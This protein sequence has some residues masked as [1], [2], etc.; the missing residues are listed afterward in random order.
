MF[1]DPTVSVLLS[2]TT[3]C[4]CLPR[5]FFCFFNVHALRDERAGRPP[6]GG[7][8]AGLAGIRRGVLL[9]VP[10]RPQHEQRRDDHRLAVREHPDHAVDGGADNDR[11]AAADPGGGGRLYLSD[12]RRRERRAHQHDAEIRHGEDTRGARRG[13]WQAE[14]Y[15]EHGR[16]GIP[17]GGPHGEASA[18]HCQH[19][20]LGV[21][22]QEHRL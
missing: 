1:A 9:A 12:W 8:P 4:Y 16:P 13:A 11:A 15:V 6:G 14:R 7:G 19:D 18:R 3:A 21:R 22:L 17:C 10:R 20:V 5:A 2:I